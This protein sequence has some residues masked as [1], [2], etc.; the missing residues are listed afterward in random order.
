VQGR[1]RKA[2]RAFARR[3][4]WNANS[5]CSSLCANPESRRQ[6]PERHPDNI[7]QWAR[8]GIEEPLDSQLL[9]EVGGNIRAGER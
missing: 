1:P 2:R 3:G 7:P 5:R 8:N 4:E 9:A 6:C